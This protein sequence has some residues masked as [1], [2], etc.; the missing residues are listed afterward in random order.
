V[1]SASDASTSVIVTHPRNCLRLPNLRL[2]RVHPKG[3]THGAKVNEGLYEAK[4]LY[5]HDIRLSVGDLEA[6]ATSFV[7]LFI[8]T[9]MPV[10]Y[11]PLSSEGEFRQ[12]R[13]SDSSTS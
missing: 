13:L 6:A 1:P 4:L 7:Q 5:G 10:V 2:K 9:C 3:L 11:K 12:N 8:K